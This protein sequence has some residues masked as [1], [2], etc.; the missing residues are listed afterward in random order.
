METQFDVLKMKG[1]SFVHPEVQ[2]SA[3][4]NPIG[5]RPGEKKGPGE[6]ADFQG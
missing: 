6:L 2:G 3:W 5:Y 4:E 1:D